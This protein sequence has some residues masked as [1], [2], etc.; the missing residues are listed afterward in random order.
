MDG[1]FLDDESVTQIT[2]LFKIIDKDCNGQLDMNDFKLRG[3]FTGTSWQ[4]WTEVR[5]KTNW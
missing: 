3:Q 5:E 2:R 4:K 1:V